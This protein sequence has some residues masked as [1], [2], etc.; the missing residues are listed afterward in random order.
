M[1]VRRHDLLGTSR[2][3]VFSQVDKF[4]LTSAV[5]FSVGFLLT[6][7][8]AYFLMKRPVQVPAPI[9][10]R[11]TYTATPMTPANYDQNGSEAAVAAL[12]AQFRAAAVAGSGGD[13]FVDRSQGEYQSM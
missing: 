7:L 13:T 5:V 8:G 9:T 1:V 2:V 3:R 12:E 4:K 6:L 10:P 11:L